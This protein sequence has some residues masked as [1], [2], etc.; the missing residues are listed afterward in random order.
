MMQGFS[1]HPQIAFEFCM[2]SYENARIRS[3]RI[4]DQCKVGEMDISNPSAQIN[5]VMYISQCEG[6]A[7]FIIIIIIIIIVIIII[8]III[9]HSYISIAVSTSFIRFGTISHVY[10]YVWIIMI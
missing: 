2:T 7:S 5:L 3:P 9:Q 4:G 6:Q 10:V 1:R 8:I